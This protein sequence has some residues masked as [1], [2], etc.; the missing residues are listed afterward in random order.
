MNDIKIFEHQQFGKVRTVLRDDEPWF[1]AVDV[2]KALE[3]SNVSMALARLDE[4]ERAKLNLGCQGEM[5]IVSEPG[6]YNLV[7]GSRK[8]EAKAF[9]RWIT[10][11]VIPAIRKT[12]A[13][14]AGEE[15]MT[16][17]ELLASALLVAQRKIDDREA[18][19]NALSAENSRLLVEAQIAAPK[20]EY[21]DQLV[22]RNLLTNFRETAQEL[23]IG[24]RAFIKFLIEK[25][26]IYRDRKGKLMPYEKKNNGLFEL[27]ERINDKSN[28]SGT[29]TFITP[30]GRETFRLLVQGL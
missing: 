20:A 15:N 23:G 29:Q 22:D 13:Y 3:H 8:P 30:K 28:W 6:L 9:K 14:I 21:F 27:K 25:K 19:M 17:D 16:D 24:E 1:V 7:L 26:Y 4:D 2:C 11:D 5:N 10:H 18:R 12:G